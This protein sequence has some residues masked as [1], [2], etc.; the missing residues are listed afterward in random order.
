MEL[1][2]G[3]LTASD[4]LLIGMVVTYTESFVYAHE[5]LVDVGHVQAYS[6]GATISPWYKI[7]TECLDKIIKVMAELALVAR[8]RPKLSSKVNDVDELFATT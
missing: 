7:R 2:T 8:G 4:E 3:P 6:T 1:N 5:R